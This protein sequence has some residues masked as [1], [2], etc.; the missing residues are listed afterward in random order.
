MNGARTGA[1]IETTAT[2]SF[3]RDSVM[4]DHGRPHSAGDE[5]P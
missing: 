5:G 3:I 4:R 1:V 2:P